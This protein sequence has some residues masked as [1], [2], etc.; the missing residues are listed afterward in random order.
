MKKKIITI[1]GNLLHKE[2]KVTCSDKSASKMKQ[3]NLSA[4]ESFLWSDVASDLRRTAPTL[5]FLLE[6]S[7]GSKNEEKDITVTVTGAILLHHFSERANLIQR[8]FSV[9]F[10]AGHVPKQVC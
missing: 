1:V 4:I 3:K 10:Y 2:I 7:M 8:L 6:S 9:L 5:V